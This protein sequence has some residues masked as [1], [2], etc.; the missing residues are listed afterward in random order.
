M[1]KMDITKMIWKLIHMVNHKSDR[2][3]RCS[4][5]FQYFSKLVHENVSIWIHTSVL[6]H[7][8]YERDTYVNFS[9][10]DSAIQTLHFMYQ[11]HAP[12]SKEGIDIH[13][14]YCIM[15]S[16]EDVNDLFSQLK[17]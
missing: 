8:P 15:T 5:T 10:L 1:F 4:K 11:K 9:N 16:S 17:L 7:L 14:A 13:K 12:A 3:L 2:E 6:P